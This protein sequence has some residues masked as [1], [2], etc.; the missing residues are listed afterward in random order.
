MP[1]PEATEALR[2][3]QS[4]ISGTNWAKTW[5]PHPVLT[6]E[7]DRF[8]I[9]VPQFHS[10]RADRSGPD[11]IVVTWEI[12]APL[13]KTLGDAATALRAT[14]TMI[15]DHE[16]REA[17]RAETGE[18]LWSPHPQYGPCET[19]DHRLACETA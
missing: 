6:M 7:G 17:G 2:L 12:R 4:V 8:L 5:A 9:A 18:W 13:P 19:D 10:G 11:L 14:L 16:V 15:F 3:Y 1:S